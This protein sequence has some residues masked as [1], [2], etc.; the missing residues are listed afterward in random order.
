MIL[1]D[2]QI[3]LPLIEEGVFFVGPLDKNM[4]YLSSLISADT[5]IQA[6]IIAAP[7]IPAADSFSPRSMNENTAVITGFRL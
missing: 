4:P 6:I 2:R 5:E 7:A 1:P 3:H